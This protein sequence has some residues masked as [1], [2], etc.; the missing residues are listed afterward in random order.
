MPCPVELFGVGLWNLFI[1]PAV[2]A[3]F[4]QLFFPYMDSQTIRQHFLDFFNNKGH[5][6]VPSAPVVLKNDP[7]LMFTNAGMNQFKDYFLGNA[8]PPSPRIADT[9]KCLRVSGKHNDL[10]DVGVD[11][12]H[13]TFFEMLGNWS[14][15]DYFKEEAIAWAWELLTGVYKIPSDRLYATYFQGDAEENLEADNEALSLWKK[16]LPDS[17]ILPGGKKD[18]FWEMGD[19][20]PCGP[21]TEIHVDLRQ[22]AERK[23]LSGDVLVNKGHPLVIELWNLVFIQYNRSASGSLHPLP[24]KH[25]DTGMGLERLCM[26]LQGKHSNYDTDLFT[27]YIFRLEELS[28]KLYGRDPRLDVAFRAIADHVRAVGACIADGQLPSNNGAGYVVRRILRRAVRYGFS[29]LEFKEPFLYKLVEV[30]SDN[31]GR[32]FPEIKA[33]K[34]FIEKIIQEEEAAFFNTIERGLGRLMDGLKQAKNNV[35]PGSVIFELY[36]TFGFPADLTQL[37]AKE[38]GYQTDMEGFEKALEAQRMRSRKAADMKTG[39]WVEVSPYEKTAFIGYDTLK[40]PVRILRYRTVETSKKQQHHL[41]LDQT[42]FYPEGGGQVGDRGTLKSDTQTIRILDTKKEN[43]LIIHVADTLPEQPGAFFEAAVDE[44]LRLGAAANHSATHLLHAALRE[45]LGVHVEQ[46]GSL[47]HPDYLRFDFSHPAKLH[48]EELQK[49]EALV[50]SRIR[51]NLPREEFR[52]IRLEEALEAG[53]TAL[54]GEKYG[55]KVRMIRFGEG[56]STELCGGTHVPATGHIGFFKIIS[57]SAIAAGVRRI[58]AVTGAG[59][60][61]WVRDMENQM[62]A[63]K[64]QLKTEDPLK[65]VE[66]LLRRIQDLEKKIE[67]YRHQELKKLVEIL[68][69]ALENNRED[70][71]VI[72]RRYDGFSA[73]DFRSAFFSVRNK[74]SRAILVLGGLHE[75]K[76]VIAIGVSDD[77]TRQ[78]FHAANFVR[79]WAKK[80]QGGGGGQPFFATAGGKDPRGLEALL[81]EAGEELGRI[82]ITQ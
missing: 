8:V 37:I 29:H 63:L 61:T 6:I 73:E 23:A 47:V 11:T 75:Q 35:L 72:I 76:P 64:H 14:F 45:V 41:V 39:D 21:C 30:L 42:P 12:Y 10:E 48:E 43:D 2:V 28:G 34:S 58:E 18:N 26:V 80:I 52:E 46:R 68:E 62:T 22:E 27:G 57:E 17:H 3:N 82:S 20:G 71:A 9:Q 13:H 24:Q 33:Q 70:L 36:D 50:N 49:I 66:G 59:A 15:G 51:A 65:Q 74:L 78:G 7:T 69:N 53:A 40:A 54:F 32:A 44:N 56:F 55:E 16:F 19:T 81:A 38:E 31:L 60:E 25:V 79:T 5:M 1:R 4:A 77:L 67:H